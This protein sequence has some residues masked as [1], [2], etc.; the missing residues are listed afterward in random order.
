MY[1][2]ACADAH[3]RQ[4]LCV[5]FVPVCVHDQV[6][7]DDTCEEPYRRQA[8]CMYSVPLCSG[9]EGSPGCAH[10]DAHWRKAFCLTVRMQDPVRIDGT[11]A[12]PVLFVL[13]S[14]MWRHTE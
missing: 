5:L 2:Q 7:I 13:T 9:K 10:A 14:H 1:Y 3:G 8:F 4:A 6:T 11:C 12:G